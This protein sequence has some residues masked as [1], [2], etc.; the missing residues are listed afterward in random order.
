MASIFIYVWIWAAKR[1]A[2]EGEERLILIC[3]ILENVFATTKRACIDNA[4]ASAKALRMDTQRIAEA[5]KIE[6]GGNC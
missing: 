6:A 5:G 2:D 1:H 4:G 3:N